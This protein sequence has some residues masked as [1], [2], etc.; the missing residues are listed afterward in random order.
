MHAS[1]TGHL[2]VKKLHG[3]RGGLFDYQMSAV[4]QMLCLLRK[5][6]RG[7][8]LAD[9]M[10][11]GKSIEMLGIHSVLFSLRSMGEDI[12][13]NRSKHSFSGPACK[14]EGRY[15]IRCPC[16]HTLSRELADLVLDGPT[17]IITPTSTSE[18]M[19]QMTKQRL[20]PKVFEI[21]LV[22]ASVG[23]DGALSSTDMRA[24]A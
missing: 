21:R 24:L 17:V 4:F 22:G 11:L 20:D 16:Y 5:G 15:M 7:G 12:L 10:G 1:K 23:A 18:Q 14:A 6:V 3:F 13:Q 9:E 2:P 8:F 19:F